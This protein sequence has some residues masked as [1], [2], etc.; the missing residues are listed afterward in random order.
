MPK[1]MQSWQSWGSHEQLTPKSKKSFIGSED[2]MN[3]LQQLHKQL[4]AK[5]HSY[6]SGTISEREYLDRIKPID[7]AI[8]NIEM[9]TLQDTPALRGSSLQ[10]SQ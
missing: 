1:L 5:Y 4:E 10:L 8:D 2:N 6:Q 7:Q 3:K 9:S